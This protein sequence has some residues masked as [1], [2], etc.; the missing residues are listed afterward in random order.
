[1][2]NKLFALIVGVS[3]VFNVVHAD[4]SRSVNNNALECMV[5]VSLAEGENQS[6]AA[7]IGI[8]YTIHNRVKDKVFKSK[9]HC[10]I[11]NSK[12][13]FSH[14]A[15]KRS[16]NHRE[17]LQMA[18]LVVWELI[19]DPTNGATFFNDDSLKK[20]PFR[21]TTKTVQ[22]DNMIFYKRVIKSSA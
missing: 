17:L 13:Q 9:S 11:V 2:V 22:L 15:V 3:S 21:S 1:M 4:Q 7:K 6:R 8:M 5:R 16:K 20:N 12:G 14:R 18:R 19:K 10:S